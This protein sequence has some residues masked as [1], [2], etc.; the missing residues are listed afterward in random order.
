ML[1][2]FK[3]HRYCFVIK[4]RPGALV[5]SFKLNNGCV[6]V[7]VTLTLQSRTNGSQASRGPLL[8]IT[9][10]SNTT[11]VTH[12]IPTTFTLSN[13]RGGSLFFLYLLL[14]RIVFLIVLLFIMLGLKSSAVKI[15]RH[16]ADPVGGGFPAEKEQNK[17]KTNHIQPEK[18][19]MLALNNVHNGG[20][21]LI[22]AQMNKLGKSLRQY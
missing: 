13:V 12:V 20:E 18:C 14:P 2:H 8:K 11:T 16:D 21:Q 19:L 10:P 5:S 1:K 22:L 17:L 6:R 4:R 3:Y 7:H 9:L 15:N